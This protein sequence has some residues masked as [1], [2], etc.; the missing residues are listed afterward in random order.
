MEV[1]QNSG[2]AICKEVNALVKKCGKPK[3]VD[4]VKLP[5]AKLYKH[6]EEITGDDLVHV[7]QIKE[8]IPRRKA[9]PSL[10]EKVVNILTQLGYVGKSEAVTIVET[11]P[12]L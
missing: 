1:G 12:D 10:E 4:A 9:I 2:Q 7:L 3:M 8:K 11:A 5:S 6:V